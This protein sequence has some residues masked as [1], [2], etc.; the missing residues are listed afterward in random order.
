MKK[1]KFLFKPIFFIIN[2]IFATWLVLTI[3]K[4]KPSD[5][6]EHK[7]FFEAPPAP[8]VVTKEDKEYLRSLALEFKYGLIDS[9]KFEKSLDQFL[10]PPTD[11]HLDAA[12][13]KKTKE[14]S[15]R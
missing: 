1:Y 13:G 10:A 6:G 4:I 7:K 12:S 2:L 3:E 15:V 5:F 9:L 11:E 8:R 14:I